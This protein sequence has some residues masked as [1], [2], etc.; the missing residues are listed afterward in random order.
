VEARGAQLPDKSY[1]AADPAIAAL[2]AQEHAA[3]I[4]Y[5]KTPVGATEFRM[6]SYFADVGDV[7]AIAV[8]N[9]A[10]TEYVAKYVKASM[11]QYAKLPVLSM[12][13]AF[14]G[15]HA[16]VNDYTDVA[17]GSLA[18]NNAADLY[19]Y[20]NSLYA[21]KVDGAQLKAWLERSA[22]R[23]HTIDPAKTEPQE[24]VNTGF[25]TYNFDAITSKD[26]RYEIDLT[27]APGQRIVNLRYLDQ[28]VAPTDEFLVATNNYRASGGGDFPG[29]DGS[30]TVLASP[31]ANRDV[32]IAYLKQVKTLTRAAHGQG[33]S[34][35]FG[36]VRTAGPV[37]FHAP[38]GLLDLAQQAGLDNVSQLRADDG[39]GKGLALYA[40]DLSR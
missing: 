14:K 20:P 23:F 38:P 6:S 1:V 3:T 24:L 9:Q 13:S 39:L 19:L 27:K 30:K 8:V 17:A 7:S 12:A 15:G 5:V 25:P 33:R 31:D 34:W 40:I 21:V 35:R 18:L 4:A 29:L 32:L 37:V 26:V 22:T 2:V 28:A 36:K 16:G 11:P 10:Q